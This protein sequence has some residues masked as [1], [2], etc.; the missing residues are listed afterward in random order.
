MKLGWNVAYVGQEKRHLIVFRLF[1][2]NKDATIQQ[3]EHNIENVD[4]LKLNSS[5]P[6]FNL[7]I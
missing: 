6:C 1:A 7:C 3:T 4:G 2:L 5:T